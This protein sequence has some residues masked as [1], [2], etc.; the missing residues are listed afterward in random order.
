MKMYFLG[1]STAASS[2]HRI[3]PRWMELAGIPGAELT[4]IDIPVDSPGERYRDAVARILDDS[5]A[6]GALVTT[7]KVGVYRHANDLFQG[8]DADARLL[9]EVSCILKRETGLHGMAVDPAACGQALAEILHGDQFHGEALIMGAGGAGLALAVQLHREHV[10]TSVIMTDISAS[11]LSEVSK[12]VRAEMRLVDGP[13][14]S[15]IER[16]SPGALIVNAT[17]IGKDRPGSPV[18]NS[19]RFP[20]GCVA[21]DLNYRGNLAWLEW[22]REQGSTAVDGWSCFLFGW[23]RI[24]SLIFDFDLTPALFTL[25]RSTADTIRRTS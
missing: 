10:P 7:H 15:L 1:V 24:L 6:L 3:F 14:D 17:G 18:T 22:A 23:S 11:R 19:V 2:I 9:G 8:F 13:Q 20:R 25:M 5:D 4:G 12:L 21:W 16:V